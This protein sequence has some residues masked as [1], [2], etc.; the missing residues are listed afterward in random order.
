MTIRDINITSSLENIDTL[1][2]KEKNISPSLR[3]AIE[4]L[5]VIVTLMIE[6]LKLN[7]KNSSTPPSQDPN[8][9]KNPKKGDSSRTTGGQKGH[10]GTT[11]R[12]VDNP[13]EIIVHKADQCSSCGSDISQIPVEGTKNRQV[14][15]V[16]VKSHIVEHQAEIKKCSC[17]QSNQA[18]FPLGIAKPIQYGSSI[19]SLSVYMSQYQMIPYN[20]ICDF[21]REQTEI[22]L[23]EGSIYNFNLECFEKLKPFEDHVKSELKFSE[24]LNVDETG[25]NIDGKRFWLH[26]TSNEDW[27][28]QFPHKKRGKIAMD[29]IDILPHFKGILCHD[30]WKPY[31]QYDCTHALCNAHHLRE[32]QLAIDIDKHSWAKNMKNLLIEIKSE[33]EAHH[34]KLPEDKQTTYIK[35]Y[36]RILKKG[37]KECPEPPP[38]KEGKRGKV[39]KTKSRNLLERLKKFESE[40]LLFMTKENV[41]FTNNAGERDIRMTKV[42]QKVSGCFRSFIGANIFCRVRSY[43]NSSLK[44]KKSPAQT[45][46]NLFSTNNWELSE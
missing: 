21:F 37:E 25:I 15:E 28:L 20:R 2:K 7:S 3:A 6:R 12:Q 14:V 4:L 5:V 38:K 44:Q 13:D 17:G 1:L 41:P 31:F 22:N 26:T 42:Q 45:I 36:R 32:L 34:G 16:I 30:H 11:L 33:M 43:I 8:R 9:K 10:E 23:S 35:E 18:H 19:K 46:F 24:I 39:K 40:T 29:E 27:T